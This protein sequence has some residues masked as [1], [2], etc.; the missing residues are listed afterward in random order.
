MRSRDV[1]K[2]RVRDKQEQT[3]IIE[4][5]MMLVGHDGLCVYPRTNAARSRRSCDYQYI[6]RVGIFLNNAF[7]QGYSFS[8]WRYNLIAVHAVQQILLNDDA[9]IALCVRMITTNESANIF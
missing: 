5:Q 1:C 9:E 7:S 3:R 8:I 6:A 2:I 4:Y